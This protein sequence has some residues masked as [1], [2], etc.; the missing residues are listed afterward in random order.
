MANSSPYQAPVDQLLQEIE[1]TTYQ[2]K[3]PDY[4]GIYGFTAADIPELKRLSLDE[5]PPAC[6]NYEWMIHGLRAVT[7]LDPTASIDLYLQQLSVFIDDEFLWE[8]ATAISLTAG[9]TAIAPYTKF[10]NNTAENEWARMSIVDGLEEIAKAD[11]DSRDACVQV[12]IDQLRMYKL[13]ENEILN[14][15]IVDN[16]AQLKAVE[17]ADLIEEVF[18]HGDLD[19]WRTGSWPAVQ[20][21]LGLKSESDFSPEELKATPPPH[22]LAIRESLD[23]LQT[24][25]PKFKP[26][27]PSAKYKQQLLDFS[28]Q[29]ALKPKNAGFGSAYP[30]PKKNKQKK[31]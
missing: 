16:L 18:T 31:R 12:L 10:L 26:V 3:W 20:V 14:S 28:N 21:Q 23:Q 13:P 27:K 30:R 9:K 17:A 1:F 24:A 19:E 29:A 11:P 7:Q 22:I 15:A 25:Q 4:V 2:Q 8:E 6:Q 5:E